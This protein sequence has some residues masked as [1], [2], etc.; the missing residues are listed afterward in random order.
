LMSV[1]FDE[2]AIARRALEP[3]GWIH[4]TSFW[5]EV[6]LSYHELAFRSRRHSRSWNEYGGIF[7]VHGQE[8]ISRFAINH[9]R[10]H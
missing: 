3:V 7:C 1:L 4:I 8:F 9:P 6:G 5:A 2:T 10:Y